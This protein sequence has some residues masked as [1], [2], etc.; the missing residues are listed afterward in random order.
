MGRH[1]FGK[2]RFIFAFVVAI[3][4]LVGGVP[5][6]GRV[7]ATLSGDSARSVAR[8]PQLQPDQL[9]NGVI[10]GLQYANPTEGLAMVSPPVANSGGGAQIEYP[11][12]I[13]PGRGITPDVSL[14]YDSGGANGWVGLG[15]DLSVGEISVDTSFGAPHFDPALESESYLLNGDLLTPNATSGVWTARV[16]ERQDYTRQV[17]TEYQQIIRHGNSPKTY[18]WE[19]HDKCGN[20]F[21]YGG[22]PDPGGPYG[23]RKFADIPDGT[24]AAD[25]HAGDRVRRQRQRRQVVPVGP[26][27]RRRQPDPLL[28]HAGHLCCGRPAGGARRRASRT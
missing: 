1:H 3:P 12:V 25:R 7:S 22:K 16:A 17:E 26:A 9:G 15:W 13:P 4:L 21:W 24:P 11:F 10:D 6:V 20:V 27:R 19:V 8:E 14:G 2:V 28:L 18:F 5:T 23:G